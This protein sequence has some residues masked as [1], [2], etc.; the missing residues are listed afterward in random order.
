MARLTAGWVLWMRS[1][2]VVNLHIVAEPKSDWAAT[3]HGIHAAL[4]PGGHLVF[5]TRDPAARAWQRWTREHTYRRVEIEGV[6]AVDA[7][8]EL[9]SVEGPLVRFASVR[10]FASDGAV[11]RSESTLRFR[12]RDEVE[13]DLRAAGFAVVDVLGAPDRPG[14]EFVF[15]ATRA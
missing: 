15:V 10:V 3:L 5:E 7:W 11:L 9:R 14:L 4:R 8:D 6:G 1:A 2:A 13:A 12:E